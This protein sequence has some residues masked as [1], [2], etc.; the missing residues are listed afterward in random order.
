MA[1][2]TLPAF[3]VFG[4]QPPGSKPPQMVQ[5]NLPVSSAED[6]IAETRYA[7]K[8][9][10]IDLHIDGDVAGRLLLGMDEAGTRL[11][12]GQRVQRVNDVVRYMLEQV[13]RELNNGKPT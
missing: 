2:K 10:H 3:K 4:E 8:R 1:R 11:N 6:L 13:A 12:N 7:A 9:R 5:L